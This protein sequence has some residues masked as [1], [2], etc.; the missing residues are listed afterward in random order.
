[1]TGVLLNPRFRVTEYVAVTGSK[2]VSVEM[3]DFQTAI[4]LTKPQARRLAK[5]L[6]REAERS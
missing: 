6:T 5:G 4:M 1:M 2:Y 3:D